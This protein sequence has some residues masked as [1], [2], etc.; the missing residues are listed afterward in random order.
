M[1]TIVIGIIL[2]VA[3]IAVVLII[4]GNRRTATLRTRFGPEYDVTIKTMRDRDRAESEL[5]KRTERVEQLKLRPLAP[6]DRSRFEQSWQA[7]Q[8]RFV[9]DPRG[10]VREADHLVTE[11]MQARGYPVADFD[12]RAADV[13]V[14]HPHAVD[15]YRAAHEIAGRDVKNEANTEDLRNAIVHF[16]ALFEELLVVDTPSTDA[17]AVS[18]APEVSNSGT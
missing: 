2:V 13:S 16:R 11:L 1:N 10:A 15:R 14:D 9:D 3:L 12:Q 7:D 5:M 8:A 6:A 18:R 17:A 4:M